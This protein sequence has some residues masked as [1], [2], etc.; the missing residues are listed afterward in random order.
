MIAALQILVLIPRH[1]I[2]VCMVLKQIVILIIVTFIQKKFPSCLAS[3]LLL[4]KASLQQ[5]CKHIV[6]E[7]AYSF[8]AL[9]ISTL[10]VRHISN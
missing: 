5:C 7:T 10:F 1:S 2:M 4:Q 8:Q 3:V 6:I 9:W